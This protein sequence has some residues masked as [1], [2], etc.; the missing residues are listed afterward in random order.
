MPSGVKLPRRR[1]SRGNSEKTARTKPAARA[2]SGPEVLVLAAIIAAVGIAAIWPA[3]SGGFVW[4]DVLIPSGRYVS[5]PDGLIKFWTSAK[6]AD[7]WPVAYSTHWFEYRAFGDWATGYRCTNVVLHIANALLLWRALVLLRVPGAWWAALIFVAHPVTVEA[8][9]WILQ[10]KT[11]LSTSFGLGTLITYLHYRG[12]PVGRAKWGWYA[13]ALVLFALGM[14]SK[15]AVVMLPLAMVSCVCLL[16]RRVTWDDWRM[17]V[18]LLLISLV[19][20]AVGMS[21]QQENAIGRDV[22]RDDTLVSRVALAGWSFWFYVYKA[23]WPL[24]LTFIYPRWPL[25]IKGPQTFVP[26]LALVALTAGV[27]YWTVVRWPRGER[28]DTAALAALAWYGLN[29][30]PVAGLV[31]IYFMR[32]SL[33]ADHWQYLSLP[34]LIA[35]LVAGLVTLTGQWKYWAVWITSAGLGAVVFVLAALSW[36]QAYI[37]AGVD[38]KPLWR[39][40]I[41]KNP[42]AWVAHNNLGSLLN[43][44]AGIAAQEAQRLA[45]QG[46]TDEAERLRRAAQRDFDEAVNCFRRALTLN[47]KYSDAEQNWG[48]NQLAQGQHAEAMRHFQKALD[49]SPPKTAEH[50]KAHVYLGVVLRTLGHADQALPHFQAAVDDLPHYVQANEELGRGLLEAGRPREAVK[51]LETALKTNP[52]LPA[53]IARLG[54]AYFQLG[55]HEEALG[56]FDHAIQLDSSL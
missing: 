2:L 6:Q 11:L 29:L 28:R 16:D 50:A 46:H 43:H 39:D 40:T 26:L 34:A 42:D 54:E 55:R 49:I 10:R 15:T 31:N 38:N 30:V 23:L 1:P 52:N 56:A 4:D 22:V 24:N 19:L 36:N 45:S 12:A 9:A 8:V 41:A 20:G 25:G 7:Y 53:T 44:D 33:V 14:L 17:V 48:M 21:F 5:A 18:P 3:M 37:Y 51:C 27:V 47:P 13:A 35:L 32:Y